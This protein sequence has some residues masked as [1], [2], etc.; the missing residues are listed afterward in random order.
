MATVF[1]CF[2]LVPPR[3]QWRQF[4]SAP[5]ASIVFAVYLFAHV[6]W[7]GAAGEGRHMV[8][9]ASAVLCTGWFWAGAPA[10]SDWRQAFQTIVY[11]TAA[12]MAIHAVWQQ[13]TASP[14]AAGILRPS[15]FWNRGSS[16]FANPNQF[17]DLLAMLVPLML[18]ETLN[19]ATGRW[20]RRF[21]GGALICVLWGLLVSQSRAGWTATGLGSGLALWIV[22]RRSRSWSR[23]RLAA[24]AGVAGGLI[25]AVLWWTSALFRERVLQTL[26]GNVR[27][28]M[29]K[30]AWGFLWQRLW[31]GHGAGAAFG[32]SL[33]YL[34]TVAMP[35]R[36]LPHNEYLW[37]WTDY[38]LAGLGLFL[39]IPVLA[40]RWLVRRL[41][42]GASASTVHA[43]AGAAG[44]VAA[45]M[46]HAFFDFSF[47]FTANNLVM[48][49]LLGWALAQGSEWPEPNTSAAGSPR[50]QA[51]RK[52]AARV[53]VFG[54]LAWSVVAGCSFSLCLRALQEMH[55]GNPA[56]ASAL[57][58]RA[59]RLDRLNSMA[60]TGQGMAIAQ[61][62]HSDPGAW[63]ESGGRRALAL[64][65]E[66]LRLN[67]WDTSA[68]WNAAGIYRR[69]GQEDRYADQLR[70][71]V[72]LDPRNPSFREALESHRGFPRETEIEARPER[73]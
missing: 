23:R 60:R 73:P 61:P 49:L 21:V 70:R 5:G 6:F 29:W 72:E 52:C 30:D 47:H 20:R 10:R 7:V 55:S 8:L 62:W 2:L 16:V 53:A 4:P 15:H 22:F 18:C 31:L 13:A 50:R 26:G 38:G 67:P 24:A 32:E 42:S 9:L 66:A 17:A 69:L 28:S 51:I 56:S 59:A 68:R 43:L 14:F 48:A 57:Y 54:L 44:L 11:L 37:L 58:G 36:M 25:L 65:E 35:E 34:R 63:S 64:F 33:R 27:L 40:W 3:M 41:N 39:A 71:L 12:G 1:L 46:T 19:P 45:R